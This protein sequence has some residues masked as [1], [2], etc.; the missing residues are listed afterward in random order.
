MAKR[1]Q[2]GAEAALVLAGYR[3]DGAA[4][5]FNH[6]AAQTTGVTDEQFA[7]AECEYLAAR[8]AYR[9]AL[10]EVLGQDVEAVARRLAA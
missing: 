1:A 6:V 2:T 10:S 8:A 5:A 9:K 7:S 4:S 3:L